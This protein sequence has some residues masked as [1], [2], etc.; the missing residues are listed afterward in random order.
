MTRPIGRKHF[1]RVPVTASVMAAGLWL[2]RS[3]LAQPAPNDPGSPAPR[4][5]PSA[6]V[7]RASVGDAGAPARADAVP[8]VASGVAPAAPPSPD[9]T[10]PGATPAVDADER[11]AEDSSDGPAGKKKKGHGDA[12]RRHGSI[13]GDPWGDEPGGTDLGGGISLRVLLQ[14]RY[15]ATFPKSSTNP[16][17]GYALR[18][19][20]LVRQGDG[21]ALNRFFVR[22]SA[23][24]SEYIGFKGILDFA[25]L[26]DDNADSVVKQAYATLRPIPKHLKFVTGLFKLPFS[27]LELDPIAKYEL[28]DLGQADDLVKDLGFGGRDLGAEMIVAPFDEPDL[29]HLSLGA[30]RGNAHDENALVF[31]AVGGR[32]ES[33][34]LKGLRLGL[35]MV[36]H[37]RGGVY[38]RPFDTK[39]K[40]VLPNPP[41]PFFPTQKDWSAGRAWSA[42]VTFE[43]WHFDLRAE[44]MIGNRVDADTTYGARTFAAVWGLASY[45]FRAGP[46][47]LMPAVRAEWL[48]GDREHPVGLRRELSFAMNVIFSKKAR[49]LLDLTRTDVEP[50]SP[51]LDQPE[52]LQAL[53]FLDLSNTR[54]VGQ[55]Q[56]EL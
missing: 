22:L 51:I 2:G 27:I 19:D 10:V 4:S 24:P 45:R 1:A 15:T 41:D 38:Q 17:P 7:P 35:D 26:I 36:E 44:A 40:H 21:W 56:V 31:G 29:M 18:E 50:G 34:P 25:E 14:T 46:I 32:L 52:P 49:F 55:L 23:E 54:L 20:W 33:R 13:P 47:H 3:S 9:P 28:A 53:P 11:D 12:D 8:P 43:R 48:D 37:P 6:E 16:Q 5:S 39:K 42:D 30:F